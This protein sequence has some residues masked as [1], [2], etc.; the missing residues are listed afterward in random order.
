M[1]LGRVG[2]ARPGMRS[3]NS[4]RGVCRISTRLQHDILIKTTQ[5]LYVLQGKE[6]WLPVKKQNRV[7]LPFY[8][9]K[10]KKNKKHIA[11]PALVIWPQNQV[12]HFVFPW[13]DSGTSVHVIRGKPKFPT[14]MTVWLNSRLCVIEREYGCAVKKPRQRAYQWLRPAPSLDCR[15]SAQQ[16]KLEN[17]RLKR[18][19]SLGLNLRRGTVPN[20]NKKKFFFLNKS[21]T[22]IREPEAQVLS[23]LKGNQDTLRAFKSQKKPKQ[24]ITYILEGD[25][26]KI[27]SCFI[28]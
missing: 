4:V 18:W 2:E 9:T 25:M 23:Y 16:E 5:R 11:N 14:S 24:N 22:V 13:S 28:F 27:L 20:N 17:S 8:K 3:Y 19:K 1:Y 15:R 6:F 12:P 26:R 21:T 7:V 10:T